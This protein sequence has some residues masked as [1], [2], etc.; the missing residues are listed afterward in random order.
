M[1][2]W[3]MNGELSPRCAPSPFD[4]VLSL[5]PTI[6]MFHFALAAFINLSQQ[7]AVY[8]QL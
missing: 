4:I 6:F 1:A 5:Q 7:A 3:D 2:M 8:I